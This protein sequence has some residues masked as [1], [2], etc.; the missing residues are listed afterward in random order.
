MSIMDQKI[1]DI[2]FNKGLITEGQID[3]VL[4]RARGQN[5]LEKLLLEEQIV[6][7]EELT[8]AVAEGFGLGY[9]DPSSLPQKPLISEI[10]PELMHKYAF[11]PI[12]KE[13]GKLLIAVHN[14]SDIVKIDELESL[15]NSK[16]DLMVASRSAIEN[17]LKRLREGE[18]LLHEI[19][20]EFRFQLVRETEAGDEV[21]SLEKLRGDESPI[22]RLVDSAIYNAV[23]KRASDIHIETTT[24]EVIVKYRIDGVLYPAMEPIQKK[25]HSSII[26]RIK[27]MSE[28]DIAE[29]RVP[30][31][32]R[33]KLK[34][35]GK[36]IDFRV[37]IMPSIFGED[38]V[39]RILDKEHLSKEFAK[40]SLDG[41]GFEGDLLAKI[42]RNTKKPYGMLLVTGPTGSGKTTTLYAAI[43]EINNE[44]DKIITIEDPVEYQLQGVVQVPVNEKKGLTFA[45]GLRSILRH[46]PDKIMV[47]EMR[48]SE[49]AQIA[50]QSALTGH[51]VFTTVHANNVIDVIGRLLNMGVEP[52]NFVSALNCILAQRLVRN[53]CHACKESVKLPRQLLEESGLD[54]EKYENHIFFEGRGCSECNNTGYHGRTTIAEFLELS[55]AI[56]EMILEKRPF[57]D[58]KKRAKE[59]GMVF[60]RESAIEKVLKGITT[61]KEI[62]RVTFVEAKWT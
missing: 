16:I 60:L 18:E 15:L 34:I 25:Y 31:D 39:I 20:E 23:E 43:T 4:S 61:L 6:G 58:I 29:K 51:L 41:L 26:S 17:I 11:I 13:N 53:I 9:I 59:E 47:G 22:V 40:L 14:P 36:T 35:N 24:N 54:A 57:A 32:G 10:S 3:T 21:I 33:F 50:V 46:D 62:N 37:S 56:R 55:D 12:K 38:A 52:Y 42:R 1:C 44:E 5:S 19:S 45:R 7:E 27:I 48:D 28:L 30:Q 49:T 8:K 2:L